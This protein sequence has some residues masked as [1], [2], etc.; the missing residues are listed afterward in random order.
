MENNL[1]IGITFACMQSVPI[2]NKDTT[3]CDKLCHLWFS[4]SFLVSST[5]KTG[6]HDL[7]AVWLNVTL[8]THDPN[9]L[10]LIKQ[11]LNNEIT[12]NVQS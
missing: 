5:N 6:H 7:A 10:I 4:S 8:I 2:T 11:S 1:A 9:P 3:L 12:L